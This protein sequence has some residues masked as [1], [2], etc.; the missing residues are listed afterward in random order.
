MKEKRSIGRV[1]DSL[2][3]ALTQEKEE[4]LKRIKSESTSLVKDLTDSMFRV[5]FW[6][7]F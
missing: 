5:I 1:F 3:N 4:Q 7:N 2:I 6:F